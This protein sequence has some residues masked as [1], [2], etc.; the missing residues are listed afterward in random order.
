MTYTPRSLV[1]DLFGDYFRYSDGE[2]RLATLTQLLCAYGIE[3]SSSRMTMSRLKKEGWFTTRR[4]GRETIYTLS[5]DM[6]QILVEGRER[7][8][9][10]IDEP[11]ARRWTMVLYQV[12][13]SARSTREA[14]RKNLAWLG[15]GQLSA[16]VWLAAHNRMTVARE[17]VNKHPH[18][19]ID[20]LWSGTE[21]VT[22]DRA[23]AQRCWDLEALAKD[24][25]AFISK[26]QMLDDPEVNLKRP[27]AEAVELRTRL[28]GDARRF[29]FRDPEL[30]IEL[31]PH[32][33]PGR[34]AYDLF[35]RLHAQLAPQAVTH[36]EEIMGAPF[37]TPPPLGM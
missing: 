11:W 13:E 35:R 10:R 20:V 30:P 14:L 24:Y 28:V 18:A 29:T 21:S 26:Y 7:I 37:R 17:L 33:W 4:E 16:S 9:R 25:A 22:E 8:F 2:V 36:V 19:E 34:E 15:F 23:L 5:D 12:P 3:P 1:M 6:M 27:G 31:Q 32:G